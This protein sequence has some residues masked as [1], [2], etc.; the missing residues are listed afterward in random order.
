[1][2]AR[3]S[4][5]LEAADVEVGDRGRKPWSPPRVILSNSVSVG[6]KVDNKGL[7][8]LPDFKESSTSTS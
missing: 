7:T 2:V 8:T 1:M 6:V 3:G 4:G 5:A